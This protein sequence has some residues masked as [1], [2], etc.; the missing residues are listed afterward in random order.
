MQ[1]PEFQPLKFHHR[2]E[3]AAIEWGP[4]RNRGGFE[5][6]ARGPVAEFL[7]GLT[8][9]TFAGMSRSEL[10]HGRG[11][12]RWIL[13]LNTALGSFGYRALGLW[14]WVNAW[15]V[16]DP[17]IRRVLL[18]LQVLGDPGCG[19]SLQRGSAPRVRFSSHLLRPGGLVATD[20]AW[21]AGVKTRASRRR[22]VSR[23]EEIGALNCQKTPSRQVRFFPARPTRGNSFWAEVAAS[24]V[25]DIGRL[26]LDDAPRRRS[27][28]R[29]EYWAKVSDRGY[30]V[31]AHIPVAARRFLGSQV[32]RLEN[33]VA[34]ALDGAGA[35][36]KWYQGLASESGAGPRIALLIDLE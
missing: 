19:I 16:L 32:K 26:A 30:V 10:L 1:M 13:D 27:R 3:T 35:F 24:T 11:E 34:D 28:P 15:D 22:V 17:K 6:P 9:A 23:L 31:G 25:R 29:G 18:A 8:V 33:V 7:Q 21:L 36:A 5:A 20:L 12:E 4:A 14:P 2:G